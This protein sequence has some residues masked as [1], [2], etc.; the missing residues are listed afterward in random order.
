MKG[1]KR[2]R[3]L[4]PRYKDITSL[5]GLPLNDVIDSLKGVKSMI[6]S[7]SGINPTL[8]IDQHDEYTTFLLVNYKSPEDNNEYNTRMAIIDRINSRKKADRK[9]RLENDRKTYE[10]L[11]KKFEKPIKL[12]EVAEHKIMNKKLANKSEKYS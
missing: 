6:E 3:E 8:F 7:E 10:K 11:K 9:E 12:D 4:R 1:S 5:D 2:A